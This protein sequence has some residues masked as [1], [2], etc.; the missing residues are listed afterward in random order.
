MSN[1]LKKQD[2]TTANKRIALA[3]LA[4]SSFI[5]AMNM[6]AVIVAIPV[7]GDEF[8]MKAALLVWITNSVMLVSA[9]LFILFGRL[10]DIYGRKKVFLYGFCLTAISS[11]LCATANSGMLLIVFRA[12]QGLA[13]AMTVG[14]SIALIS[15]VFPAEERGKALGIN[16]AALYLGLASGPTL[17]GILTQQLGWRSLFYLFGILSMVVAMLVLWKLRSEWAEAK[18]EKLDIPGMITI[19]LSLGL[20]LVS[21][22]YLPSLFAVVSIL[23]GITGMFLFVRMENKI[24]FPVLDIGVFRGNKPFV[25]SNLTTAFNYIAIAAIAFFASLYLQYIKGLTPQTAGFILLIQPLMITIFTVVSGRLTER[26]EPQFIASIGMLIIFIAML[27]LAFLTQA[28]SLSFFI[29]YLALTGLGQGLFITPNIH[30][31]MNSVNTRYLGTASGIQ[32]TSRGLGMVLG[33]GV[34]TIVF[35]YLIGD[36]QITPVYYPAFMLSMKVCFAVSAVL[37][38]VGIFT[39]FAGRNKSKAVSNSSS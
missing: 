34:A 5:S 9:V 11:F 18:G 2:G 36:V 33:L 39:Q 21:F 3:I 27:L 25:F 8:A 19:T 38:F 16:A 13:G 29:F 12:V 35:N 31:I 26:T 4:L 20:I 14:T 6:N 10:A 30:A 7:I 37:S 28:T 24:E 32:A 1:N 22:A 23:L 15:T 17:G